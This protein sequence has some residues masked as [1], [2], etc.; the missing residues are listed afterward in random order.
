MKAKNLVVLLAAGSVAALLGAGL[1]I[2][3]ARASS[4]PV[5][6]VNYGLA[7][8]GLHLGA[9]G[10]QVFDVTDEIIAV[11]DWDSTEEDVPKDTEVTA[12]DILPSGN[13]SLSVVN[14]PSN[15]SAIPKNKFIVTYTPNTNYIGTDNYRYR[16]CDNADVNG[17]CSEAD[18]TIVVNA[19]ND[20]PIAVDDQA[21]TSEDTPVTI[22]VL[23][24]DSDLETGTVFLESFSNPSQQ[25]GSVARDEN[26]TP[27][28]TS[29]DRL[30]Y[31]PPLNFSGTDTFSYTIS[32]GTAQ[33][34]ATVTVIVHPVND[35]PTAASDSYTATQDIPLDVPAWSG[36][37][38]NDSDP[39]GDSL[40]AVWESGPS[41]G[42]LD[43][44]ADGGFRYTPNAGFS[45]QD[46]F[47][48]HATDGQLS[49]NSTTVTIQVQGNNAP[50]VANGDAYSVQINGTLTVSA[51]GVLNNDTDPDGDPLT[52]IR[53]EQDQTEHGTLVFNTDGSFTYMPDDD[54]LG[55]DKFTYWASDGQ[56][57]SN[58]AEV[59]INVS[60]S[61]TQQPS[62][63][64]TSPV[65][66]QDVHTV[67]NQ[68]IVLEVQ[69]S[70]NQAVD[71][72][73][74]Y[75]WD[76]I[77]ETY[78]DLATVTAPPYRL[79]LDTGTLNLGWNQI[80]AR[81][82]DNV[83]N[84]SEVGYIWLYRVMEFFLPVASR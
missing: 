66:D 6:F 78:M 26:G 20:P 9:S 49:S 27:F 71:R 47:T 30:I 2:S 15:G 72:V 34:S 75:R 3:G 18:V 25:G 45:G 32:D 59:V 17:S 70:D 31:T 28:L 58:Q 13:I 62:V 84:P 22:A 61:D 4:L 42:I 21:E 46:S 68:I 57:I 52:A 54:F 83:G 10:L 44:H 65:S 39:E 23:D 73:L 74:F 53:N 79:E 60:A 50:P 80:S 51:P 48:Y 38:A 7:S 33:D 40:S 36:V 16:I 81:A 67:T 69:A 76:A 56:V 77:H 37:L 64:W 55:E 1:L 63:T 41:N 35:P 43:L 29:D 14:S 5:N 12:N 24:N 11:D 82:Y 19:V 8:T